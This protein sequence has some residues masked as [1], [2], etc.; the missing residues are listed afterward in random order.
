VRTISGAHRH[1]SS[2]LAFYGHSY[3]PTHD[4]LASYRCPTRSLNIHGGAKS[5]HLLFVTLNNISHTRKTLAFYMWIYSRMNACCVVICAD[6]EYIE[7]FLFFCW[8]AFIQATNI[9]GVRFKINMMIRNEVCGC[10]RSEQLLVNAFT[11]RRCFA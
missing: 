4:G 2:T 1:A 6:L 7:Y 5:K 10:R 8:L 11:F 3:V 9:Q